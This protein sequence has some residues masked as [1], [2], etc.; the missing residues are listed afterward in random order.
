[1]HECAVECSHTWLHRCVGQGLW[2]AF[3]VCL[4]GVVFNLQTGA[5][6]VRQARAYSWEHVLLVHHT[7]NELYLKQSKNQNKPSSAT[8]NSSSHAYTKKRNTHTAWDM[9]ACSSLMLFVML[10]SNERGVVGSTLWTFSELLVLIR[11]CVYDD[12]AVCLFKAHVHRCL[13]VDMCTHACTCTI[14]VA[15]RSYSLYFFHCKMV[16][17]DQTFPGTN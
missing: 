8:K 7:V 10:E 6:R 4:Q 16:Y 11:P 5:M 1:M 2:G 13:L 17:F 15:F 9:N 14:C 3:W 12:S